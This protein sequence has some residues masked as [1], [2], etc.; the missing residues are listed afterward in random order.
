M[1]QTNIGAVLEEL[2]SVG[3]PHRIS[4]GK[5]GIIS[6][7][8]HARAGEESED[9]R[10]TYD[11]ALWTNYNLHFP[12]TCARSKRVGRGKVVLVHF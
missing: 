8:T 11:K 7:G 9:E 3:S 6:E 4:F 2:L 5:D 12:F 10:A 1:I